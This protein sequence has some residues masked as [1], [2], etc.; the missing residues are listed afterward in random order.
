M[1]DTAPTTPERPSGK[2]ILIG[3]AVALAVAAAGLVVF[4]LPAEYGIDPTGVGEALGVTKLSDAGEENIYLKRGEAR[5]NVLFPVEGSPELS[6][7]DVRDVF[8]EKGVSYAA[9]A[10][11]NSDRFT[12]ELLPY[13]G[14]ELKYVLDKGAPMLF[15]WRASVPVNVDM[16]SHPFE[17]GTEATESFVIADLPAQT[18]AYVA[19]FTGIHGWYWQ[20]RS[21]GN[22][23]L[24]LDAKGAFTAS[25]IFDQAGEHD[26][27]LSPPE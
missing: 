17:G 19:P 5:T 23:T 15:S 12:F 3:S 7:L 22:V 1:T 6:S 18:A 16:H 27:E 14:I 2:R 11:L 26:R 10:E 20:N 9:D 13:E 24:T 4:V 21:L 25:K 8:A